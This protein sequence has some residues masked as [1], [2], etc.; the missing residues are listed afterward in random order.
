MHVSKNSSMSKGIFSTTKKGQNP[1]EE[2]GCF[3]SD[4]LVVRRHVSCSKSLYPRMKLSHTVSV[5]LNSTQHLSD[6]MCWSLWI[7]W[8]LCAWPRWCRPPCHTQF[9]CAGRTA[10]WWTLGR[11]RRWRNSCSG[12]WWWICRK[13]GRQQRLYVHTNDK[14]W[15]ADS[16]GCNYTSTS[17]SPPEIEVANVAANACIYGSAALILHIDMRRCVTQMNIC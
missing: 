9:C 3:I 10:A 5:V 7:I 12:L 11:R 14:G 15:L 6:W 8:L 17:K 4:T 16:E 2:Y 1:I 13:M